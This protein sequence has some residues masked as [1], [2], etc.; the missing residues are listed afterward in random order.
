[1]VDLRIR[2][3]SIGMGIGI[4]AGAVVNRRNPSFGESATIKVSK[5]L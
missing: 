1:V 3:S 2:F 4:T 5:T